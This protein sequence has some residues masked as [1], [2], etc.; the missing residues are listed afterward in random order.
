MGLEVMV[1]E[2]EEAK[3]DKKPQKKPLRYWYKMDQLVVNFNIFAGL[4]F[5]EDEENLQNKRFVSSWEERARWI[6][7]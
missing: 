5:D 7:D 6:N 1:E 4:S 3:T 2:T